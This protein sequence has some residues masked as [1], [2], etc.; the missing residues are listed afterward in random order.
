MII[1]PE[2]ETLVANELA[3]PNSF[4]NG[5]ILLLVAIEFIFVNKHCILALSCSL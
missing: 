4:V 3:D 5:G 2:T 1:H